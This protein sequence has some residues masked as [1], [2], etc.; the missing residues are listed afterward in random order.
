MWTIQLSKIKTFIPKEK[1]MNYV[2]VIIKWFS[3]SYILLLNSFSASLK[4]EARVYGKY[5]LW[6]NQWCAMG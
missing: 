6:Q 3:N 1:N 2:T 4:L 5:M